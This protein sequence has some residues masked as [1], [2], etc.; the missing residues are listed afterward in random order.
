MR[1]IASLLAAASLTALAAP[2]AA[3]S[4]PTKPVTVIVPFPAGGGTD[5]FAR[6][7]YAQLTKQFG[8]QV[9]V[10][11]RG[12]AGGNIGATLAAK[13]APDG[14][15]WF[16]GAVHHAIAPA[17]YPKLD[18]N[19]AKDFIPVALVASVPQVIVVN[20]QKVAA[21]DLKEL[22]ATLKNNTKLHYASAGNGTSHHLAGELFKLETKTQIDHIPY[23]GAGPALQDLVGGQVEMMFDGLGSSASHI[24]SGKLKA[25][26]VASAKRASG[27]P[28]IPTTV[29][30]G[31]PGYQTG[32]WY[33]LWAPKGTPQPVVD[34][35]TEELKKAFAVETLRKQ[36]QDLGAEVPNLYGA[37]FGD[38][39]AGETKRWAAVVKAA[40]VRLD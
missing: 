28:D 3:Q 29:E 6:P 10:D 8:Q 16:M 26:A 39:V 20:P 1:L 23:K 37:Q 22:L 14:Y 12:G 9:I 11:N 2:A 15:T 36:W 4:W 19:L 40:N 25:I 21:K 30:G 33:G 38:F 34:R 17:V 7:L 18:Y 31:V 35:M 24:R 13:A 5:A 32:T 27:F